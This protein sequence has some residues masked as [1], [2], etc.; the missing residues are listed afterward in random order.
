[1]KNTLTTL[2]IILITF[3]E[4]YAGKPQII[5]TGENGIQD[6]S[7]T[8]SSTKGVV[9]ED[10]IKYIPFREYP[11]NCSMREWDS[12]VNAVSVSR[13]ISN[14]LTLTF[15]TTA[16]NGDKSYFPNYIISNFMI[17]DSYSS[18]STDETERGLRLWSKGRLGIKKNNIYYYCPI[19]LK[20]YH[21]S[22]RNKAWMIIYPRDTMCDGQKISVRNEGM[23][24]FFIS[25][26]N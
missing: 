22:G 15:N 7:F 9:G 1:M 10:C 5:L 25:S 16:K 24:H 6:M 23:Y 20:Q 11:S 3:S 21:G 13:Y 26:P 2:I 8:P 18:Y 19:I 12:G 17:S 14:S 4:I